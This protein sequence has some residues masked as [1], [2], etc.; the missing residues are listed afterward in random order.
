MERLSQAD[1]SGLS[2]SPRRLAS[3]NP[4]GRFLGMFFKGGGL[5]VVQLL[6]SFEQSRPK[7]FR[8]GKTSEESLSKK[9]QTADGRQ[10]CVCNNTIAHSKIFQILALFS[11]E[12][13]GDKTTM[14]HVAELYMAARHF[15]LFCSVVGWAEHVV[16]RPSAK[17]SHVAESLSC[18]YTW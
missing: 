4:E 2:P 17:T 16:D 12:H 9:V 5:P 7:D 1:E 18:R 13:L 14:I 8:T 15:A 3:S 11:H 6:N 10:A